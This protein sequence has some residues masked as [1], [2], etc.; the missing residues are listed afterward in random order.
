[1]LILQSHSTAGAVY[2]SCAL[3]LHPSRSFFFLPFSSPLVTKCELALTLGALAEL[4][5]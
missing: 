2:R 3:C 5:A 4:P 1:M